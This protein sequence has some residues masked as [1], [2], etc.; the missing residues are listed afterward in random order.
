MKLNLIFKNFTDLNDFEKEFILRH[1][2]DPSIAKFMK[3][4]YIS[5]E[6]HLN[7]IQNLKNDYT[8]RYFLV[9]ENNQAIGVIDFINITIN[10]CEFGLYGI[11]KGVGNLLMEEIKKYAFNVLKVKILKACVF[12]ENVKA[13]KLYLKHSPIT[14]TKSKKMYY[15]EYIQKLII[16]KLTS[17]NF[18]WKDEL[19]NHTIKNKDIILNFNYNEK[20]ILKNF[21]NLNHKE[22]ERIR[23]YRNH[24]KT[25][26]HLY[27][28]HY[29]TKYEHKNFINNLKKNI[30][31][32]YYCVIYNNKI[33]GNINF[34]K[35]SKDIIEFGFYAN[36]F[37]KILG[38]GRILEHISIYYAFVIQNYK[39]L[40][41]EVFEDNI[42]IINLHKIFKFNIIKSFSFKNKTIFKMQL[43]NPN[44]DIV[45]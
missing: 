33:L 1:R 21:I 5:Y 36:P 7:F 37:S 42:Q 41:L 39:F 9:Y 3:T 24:F 26:K 13:L 30:Q 8:K 6:E 35:K 27:Q 25:K 15:L 16:T 12:K 2:N 22:K 19:I 45:S 40:Q 29:I 4:N 32:N 20:I 23:L 11:K 34:E 14:I 44:R 28:T 17:I 18:S 31:K 43:D 38:L 10:S